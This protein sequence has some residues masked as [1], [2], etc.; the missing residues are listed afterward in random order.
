MKKLPLLV[1]AALPFSALGEAASPSPPI[2]AITPQPFT[3][4]IPIPRP[5]PDYTSFIRT[6]RAPAA[7]R[8]NGPRVYGE[9][10]G[11]PFFYHLPVTGVRPM[12]ISA[13]GLPPGLKLDSLT[14]NITG[15]AR[16]SGEYEVVLTAKNSAGDDR[17]LLRVVIGAAICLT[18]PM[19]WDGWNCFAGNVDA[20][21][22]RAA[23]DAMVSSGLI[24]HGWT[25]I[26]MDDRWEGQRDADGNIQPSAQ[27]IPDMAKLVDYI[28]GKG[29]KVGIYSSPGPVTC[30]GAI[31]SWQHE[32]QDAATF[33]GWGIDYLKYE[34]CSYTNV[35]DDVREEMYAALLP[36]DKAKELRTLASEYSALSAQKFHVNPAY[37]PRGKSLQQVADASVAA[38]KTR[39]EA[40]MELLHGLA[41]QLAP[42]KVAAIA[43]EVNKEPYRKMRGSLDKV[44][45]DI[46]FSM[47]QYG[48][49]EV[50]KWGAETGGNLWRTGLDINPTW[51]SVESHGF[52][53]NGLEKWAG[54]GHWNDP[55]MLE[56]GNGALTPDENYTHMTLWCMLSAPL[57]IGCDLPKM[58]PF[59]ASLLS[60]DEVLAIDQDSLGKQGWR[61][62]ED[63]RNE[64]WMKPLEGGDVAVAFFNRGLEP[65]DVSVQWSELKLRG[66]QAVRDLWR[67]KEIGV[68]K[69]GY[70]VQVAPH[71][72]EL[73]RLHPQ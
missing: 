28:H 30:A 4:V 24:D 2:V 55:D 54:P 3:P 61:A 36:P 33:A 31:G 20:G 49:G 5:P 7:P 73:F 15:T 1:L 50:W 19:G 26:N 11:H 43:Q 21:K 9:R 60:N 48:M 13:H 56:I 64:V 59:I 14:G 53:E 37:A 40:Q 27:K 71:G 41:R 66:P 63:G 72:A 18:P 58:T 68:E 25:Y 62:K 35:E 34:L 69:S 57:I 12:T 52:G 17:A 16:G 45:R 46:V 51:N 22:L 67:Q 6:P 44:N 10:P 32:D 47:C 38:M 65:A 8:I 42:E 23:A 29:L 39:I 70:T